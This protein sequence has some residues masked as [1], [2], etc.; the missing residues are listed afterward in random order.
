MGDLYFALKCAI[1]EK[2]KTH[3]LNFFMIT[4][5][6][7]QKVISLL[8]KENPLLARVLQRVTNESVRE[9]KD[10]SFPRRNTNQLRRY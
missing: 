1:L 7:D 3:I 6:R 2:T 10:S 4:A 8:Q 9:K 5:S